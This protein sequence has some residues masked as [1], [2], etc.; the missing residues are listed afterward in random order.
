MIYR[1]YFFMVLLLQQVALLGV[2]CLFIPYV[3]SLTYDVKKIT[4]KICDYCIGR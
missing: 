1:P 4:N 3:P 2:P